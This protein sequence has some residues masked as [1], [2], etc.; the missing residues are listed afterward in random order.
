MKILWRDQAR[1]D[2]TEGV[3]FWSTGDPAAALRISR[4]IR[5]QVA[6][7]RAHPDLGRPCRTVDTRELDVPKTPFVVIYT[8]DS[9]RNM[10]IILRVIHL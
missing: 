1:R 3:R 2:V 5:Q 4:A 8:V 10:L 7:L 6:L 9:H